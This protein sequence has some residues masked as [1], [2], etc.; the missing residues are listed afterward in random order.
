MSTL[1]ADLLLI[2]GESGGVH[3][4]QQRLQRRAGVWMLQ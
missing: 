3:L 2:R 1:L 4:H